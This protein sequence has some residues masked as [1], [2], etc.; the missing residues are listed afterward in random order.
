[1]T[2]DKRVYQMTQDEQAQWVNEIESMSDDDLYDVAIH[3]LD[4]K[5]CAMEILIK[6]A[7]EFIQ[8]TELNLADASSTRERIKNNMASEGAGSM[9]SLARYLAFRV[10]H[11]KLDPVWAMGNWFTE[12]SVNA[13]KKGDI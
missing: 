3:T 11:Y 12:E 8:S 5:I 10:V 6:K 13:H 2:Q 1:M 9:N 7:M 4:W